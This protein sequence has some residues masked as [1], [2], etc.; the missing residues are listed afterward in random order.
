MLWPRALVF[1][2]R[3][4][5]HWCPHKPGAAVPG[6]GV[7][8]GVGSP[9]HSVALPGSSLGMQML[10]CTTLWGRKLGLNMP[11]GGGGMLVLFQCEIHWWSCLVCSS[12]RS[13]SFQWA[14]DRHGLG[15][16]I[17]SSESTQ[18]FCPGLAGVLGNRELP[19]HPPQ[20]ERER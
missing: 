1:R 13:G 12:P 19:P 8:L 16:F 17:S 2:F 20:R 10:V 5:Q 18:S 14:F 11:G 9:E 7:E 15:R 3:T 4:K 6:A